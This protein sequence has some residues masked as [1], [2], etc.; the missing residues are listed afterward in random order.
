MTIS[1]IH[2]FFACLFVV[3]FSFGI[4]SPALAQWENDDTYDPFA[5]YS[6]YE[7]SAEEE[8][9]INFFKT[10]RLFTMGFHAGYRNFTQD[11][12]DHFGGGTSFGLF[13]SYFFDL[14]FALQVG[15]SLSD[16][17]IALPTSTPVSGNVEVN[18]VSVALK[19]YINPQAVTKGLGKLNPYVSIGMSQINR[20]FTTTASSSRYGKDTSNGFTIAGG[21]EI[22]A[23]RNKMYYGAQAS[24]TM[25]SMPDES[26]PFSNPASTNPSITLNGDP[27]QLLFILGVNF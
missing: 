3:L 20:T 19:Y 11:L 27:Y 26:V 1:K 7:S 5:D 22:P 6:D 23:M 16:H 8:A 9:D 14:R 18:D 21:I 13:L 10:G 2:K 12:K 15:F 25:I 17:T 24:Y 4:S